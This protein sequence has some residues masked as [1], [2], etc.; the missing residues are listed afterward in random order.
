MEVSEANSCF[1]KL[2]QDNEIKLQGEGCLKK[3]FNK[4]LN[5]IKGEKIIL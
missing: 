5:K 2:K 1:K 4:L 3:G